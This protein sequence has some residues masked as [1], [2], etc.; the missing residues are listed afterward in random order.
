LEASSPV[1][2][3]Y[4][5]QLISKE[6]SGNS[7]KCLSFWYHMYGDA[8]MGSLRVFVKRGNKRWEQWVKTGNRGNQWLYRTITVK[9]HKRDKPFKVRLLV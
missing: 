8:G 3:G 2:A 5:G 6:F 1:Q 7:A 4:R 9:K